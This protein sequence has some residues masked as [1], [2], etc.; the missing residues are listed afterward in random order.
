MPITIVVPFGCVFNVV[1]GKR[2]QPPSNLDVSA[3]GNRA[4][5]KDNKVDDKPRWNYRRVRRLAIVFPGTTLSAFTTTVIVFLSGPIAL[6]FIF[7]YF[8]FCRTVRIVCVFDGT[9]LAV[10]GERNYCNSGVI[11]NFVV[12]EQ[13]ED[14]R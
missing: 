5:N 8:A 11:G 3:A 2:S 1:S 7:R 13:C 14:T 6:H 9:G 4:H 10:F 12:P